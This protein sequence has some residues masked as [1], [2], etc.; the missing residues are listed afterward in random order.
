[1]FPRLLGTG[2][3]STPGA[4]AQDAARLVSQF[5]GDLCA[6]AMA[7]A[8]PRRVGPFATDSV[9]ARM[10]AVMK[11]AL[12]KAPLERGAWPLAGRALVTGTPVVIDGIRPGELEGIVNPAMD[13]YLG[14]FGL[15]TVAFLPMR[16]PDGGAKGI[17]GIGR[18]PGRPA[19]TPE[20]IEAVQVIADAVAEEGDASLLTMLLR[21]DGPERGLRSAERR[22]AN[23]VERLPAVVYEA[24]PGAEGRW[25]YVSGFVETLL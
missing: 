20:E 15:S 5:V 18:G 16:G 23:L 8:D 7:S 24:E 13:A 9:D 11:E 4:G 21:R 3:G 12:A 22:F 17:V 19:F 1:M 6:V 10:T 25:L 14:K 2:T